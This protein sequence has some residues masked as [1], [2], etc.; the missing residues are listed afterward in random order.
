[1]TALLLGLLVATAKDS[2][3]DQRSDVIEIAGK[4]AFLDRALA[5]YGPEARATRE[6]LRRVSMKN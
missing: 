3:D 1:M 6:L 5:L 4:F 2:Y